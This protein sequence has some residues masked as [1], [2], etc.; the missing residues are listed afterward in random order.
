VQLRGKGDPVL[1]L[2]TP[3]GIG[4]DQQAADVAAINALNRQHDAV[5]HDPEIATRIAQY[6]MAFQ[7]Q[8]S[9]P[10]L[11]DVRNETQNTL[12]L[13]GCQ[14]GDGSFAANC[15]LARRLAERGVRFIQLYHK[16]WDHHGG[17][18]EGVAQKALEI[19]RACMA[20]VTDLKRRSMLD[21]TL[22]VWAGEFGRTPMSQGGSGRD[23]HNKAMSV[24]L[25]GGGVRG[26]MVYGASDDLGYAAVDQASNVHDLHATMLHQLGIQHDAFSVKFQGL[27][28]RLSGVEGAR[29]INEILA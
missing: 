15:L 22:I 28:A 14:P 25:C 2:T 5:V 27:D 16:D 7:M 17:V 20:L 8:A 11:M 10:E 6:E 19:D 12:E 24:W 18:K 23:H 4:Q 3:P 9:V 21:E 13:Y 1:Y 29:V 26:G